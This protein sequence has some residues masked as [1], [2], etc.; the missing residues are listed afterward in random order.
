ME[1]VSRRAE[2]RSVYLAYAL[3][4]VLLLTF[5]L[6][7]APRIALPAWVASDVAF[8]L[9]LAASLA[10]FIAALAVDAGGAERVVA[11]F[12]LP[13]PVLG[14]PVTEHPL[15]SDVATIAAIVQT[16]AL[17]VGWARLARRPLAR[18]QMM[19]VC[20]S[21]G[22][23]LVVAFVAP[24]LRSSDT[25]AYAGYTLLADPYHVQRER[26]PVAFRAIE[27]LWSYPMIPSVYGPLW[28]AMAHAAAGAF[29]T[30]GERIHVMRA[31]AVL[32][33]A[34]VTCA[35]ARLRGTQ[36]AL[37]LF[38]ANPGLLNQY[39]VDAHNDL[40]GIGFVLLALWPEARTVARIGLLVAAGSIKL[41]LVFLG[42]VVF[43]ST[44]SQAIRIL[45]PCSAVALTL[46]IAIV[47]HADTFRTIAMQTGHRSLAPGIATVH[48]LL[49]LV[50]LGLMTA[51]LLWRRFARFGGYSTLAIGINPSPWYL[52]WGFPYAIAAGQDRVFLIAF[53]I[54]ASLADYSYDATPLRLFVGV[55]IFAIILMLALRELPY[56]LRERF[57]PVRST[58]I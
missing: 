57:A 16:L 53:P 55:A 15:C 39:V 12:V 20:A 9:A 50:C 3:V 33:F 14:V 2:K 21:I 11:G 49:V 7:R 41:P 35:Y 1:T 36:T 22:I 38:V 23:S 34:F 13:I 24:V 8:G 27:G 43:A 37:V 25:Y 45:A 54:V 5:D 30:L 18:W 10:S 28:T 58:T 17:L 19:A 40:W 31:L 47:F 42:A 51:A 29:S 26:F 52:G 56:V 4:L 32:A 44:R 46:I 6:K 48:Y